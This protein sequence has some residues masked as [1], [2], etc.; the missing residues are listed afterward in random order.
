MTSRSFSDQLGNQITISH[1][2]QRIISLVPS[3]T[4]LLYDLGLTQQVAGITKFCVHP[5]HWL[6]EK[7]IV[8]GT[9]NF[10]FDIIEKINPD[11][12]IGNK[13]ENYK[14]GIEQLQQKYPVWVSDII[15]LPQ[16]LEMI[17]S[18]GALTSKEIK[19]AEIIQNITTAFNLIKK[20]SPKRVLYLI[21]RKPWMAAG[22]GTFIHTILE[23][24]GFVNCLETKSRYP[25]LSDDEIRSLDPEIILLS[26][27]PYPFAEK[28]RDEL[29]TLCPSAKIVL[30][31]GE[32]FSW[33]GSRLMKAPAY[34]NELVLDS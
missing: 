8:G 15:S 20:R 13:E 27:E 9:K 2:P 30:V 18:V 32:M 16:A 21:W 19:A 10:R 7:Q 34:F 3:Q 26:S 23:L 33:Y 1:P 4:E 11:L 31:D 24:L 29:M 12:I 6:T 28:H 25:E 17:G 14:E 5:D 22:T